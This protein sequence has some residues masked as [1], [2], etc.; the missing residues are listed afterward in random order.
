MG[1][2]I[3]NTTFKKFADFAATVSGR[4]RL[5]VDD[6]IGKNGVERTV[7][8]AANWDFIGNVKRG[9]DKRETNDAVRA[10]FRQSVAELFGG[11]AHIPD[12]V[13]EAMELH[14]FG[15]GKPLTAR[16]II[17]VQKAIEDVKSPSSYL[18]YSATIEDAAAKMRAIPA[19][20]D[21]NGRTYAAADVGKAVD[22]VIAAAGQDLALL[23]VLK[24]ELV[25]PNIINGGKNLRSEDQIKAKVA[26]IKAN[27]DEL[28]QAADGD[29]SLFYT[30]LRGLIGMRGKP[31]KA[32]AIASIIDQ[33]KQIDISA[34]RKLSASSSSV[35]LHKAISR[36]AMKVKEIIKNSKALEA[37]NNPAAD[38]VGF[39]A[40]MIGRLLI[41][42]CSQSTQAS[43]LA[44]FQTEACRKLLTG[45]DT[46]AFGDPPEMRHDVWNEMTKLADYSSTV[47]YDIATLL[48]PEN[49]EPQIAVPDAD[50]NRLPPDSKL[51][52]HMFAD[53]ESCAEKRIDVKP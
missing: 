44:S 31:L 34:L 43:I 11:E 1:I 35:Q 33:V 28:R 25:L 39:V 18:D 7:K 52:K 41:S 48:T 12:N 2:D 21:S 40:K 53:L 24:D 45:Y 19:P 23:N 36:Y 14:N 51:Y 42:R 15:K 9:A 37:F 46:I 47:V 20:R 49:E 32:G 26:A 29:M 16:R 13:K 38:Q 4:T 17:A 27:V 10:Y 6:R 50:N 22:A 30:G 5:A 3:S 8:A